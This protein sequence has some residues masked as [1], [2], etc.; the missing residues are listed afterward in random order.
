MIDNGDQLATGL[1][2]E[3][4]AEEPKQKATKLEL[5]RGRA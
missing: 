4:N 3:N 1:Q 2:T 5:L